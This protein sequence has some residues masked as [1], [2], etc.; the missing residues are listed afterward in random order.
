MLENMRF[1]EQFKNSRVQL[2][3]LQILNFAN[4]LYLNTFEYSLKL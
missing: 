3:I 2:A 1:D 4:T